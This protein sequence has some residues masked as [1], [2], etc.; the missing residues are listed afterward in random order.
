MDADLKAT[1][2]MRRKTFDLWERMVVIPVELVQAFRAIVIV[3]A[4]MVL[5]SA[6]GGPGAFWQNALH[7]GS[8]AVVGLLCAVLAGAV[9]TPLLLPWLPGRAFSVKGFA[10]S[11]PVTAAVVLL[12]MWYGPRGVHWLE[13]WAWILIV[14]AVTTFLAMNFTGAS[15]YTSLSGVKK[16]M[17][18][19]VPVEIAAGAA[20]LC[21]WLASVFIQ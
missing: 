6:L 14:P 3:I 7:Y 12:G 4:L 18:W 2:E 1:P 16:E 19:A 13:I 9:L 17:R 5:V 8:A 10:V 11:I 21:F 20:G 15:T